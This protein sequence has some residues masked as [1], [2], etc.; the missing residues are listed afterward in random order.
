MLK[1]YDEYTSNEQI[2]IMLR[3][4]SSGITSG[5]ETRQEYIDYRDGILEDLSK[6][7][8]LDMDVMDLLYNIGF[9]LD[10]IGTYFYKEVVVCA[11]NSLKRIAKN[12]EYIRN[13]AE[14]TKEKNEE[15]PEYD[16]RADYTNLSDNLQNPYSELYRYLAREEH[17]MGC[18]TFHACIEEAHRNVDLSRTNALVMHKVYSMCGPEI[19]MGEQAYILGKC[20]TGEQGYKF[21]PEGTE[22]TVEKPKVKNLTNSALC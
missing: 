7:K 5:C 4:L 8:Q 1:D 9:D 6:G 15:Y 12:H 3:D 17:W 14:E 19:N 10:Q 2:L 16:Y 13:R 22:P 21:I 18:K 11:A 20:I